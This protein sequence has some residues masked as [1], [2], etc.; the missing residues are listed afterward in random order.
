[1]QG[2]DSN[3]AAVIYGGIF[4]ITSIFFNA[5]WRYASYKNRLF[6]RN[7]DPRLVQFI[8]RQYSFGPIMYLVAILVAAFSA[9][10]SLLLSLGMAVFFAIPNRSV[11]KLSEEAEKQELV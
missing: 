7:T 8:T 2:P 9:V 1:L 10:A 6:D 4:F 3:V 11:E 5:L